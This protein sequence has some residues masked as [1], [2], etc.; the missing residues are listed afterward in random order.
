M[1]RREELRDMKPARFFI[2]ID[3]V[4]TVVMALTLTLFG[5]YEG[6]SADA[7]RP[8]VSPNQDFSN[9][10][11]QLRAPSSSGWHEFGQS[12]SHIEFGKSGASANESYVA[13]LSLFRHPEFP[14]A[15]AFIEFVREG[16]IK[17]SPTERFEVIESS[18]QSSSERDYPCIRYHG[19]SNDREARVSAF[20]KKKMRIEIVALYCE[21]PSKPGIGFAVSFSHRGGSEELK[22]DDEAA[23]FIN[24]VQAKVAGKAS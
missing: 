10:M 21:Y 12:S 16:V 3:L 13:A 15:D 18:V 23:S 1:H 20:S 14:N 6:L 9:P 7:D 17:E 11:F 22:I 4:C 2:G 24:S 19:I 8:A 5:S